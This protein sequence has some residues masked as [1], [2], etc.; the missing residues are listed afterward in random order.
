MGGS[1][2]LPFSFSFR[3]ELNFASFLTAPDNAALLHYLQGFGQ[4][5]DQFCF[6][7]GAAGSG[8]THLL[9]A[10]CHASA[11][12]VYL[13]LAQLLEHGPQSLDGL[14]AFSFLVFDDVQL[15]AGQRAW[16]ER[17]FQ[18]FNA[19]HAQ[20]AHICL[21]A[22]RNP[23][24]LPFM[25]ADLRSRL[26]LSVVFEVQ[27]LDEAGRQQVLLQRAQQRGI[28]LKDEVAAYIMARSPR[29]MLDL[30]A[31]LDRLDML[32]LSEKRRVTIPFIRSIFNW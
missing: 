5:E 24:A 11:T 17:L 6:L 19:M 14:D 26:Q 13:P 15:L 1:F 20:R 28:E 10:L 21:A 29:G 32:S 3:E 7:W 31:V 30:L 9:Q 22:D 8:K 4:G 27:P 2:Q 25:L 23:A 12:A 16:E 18:L